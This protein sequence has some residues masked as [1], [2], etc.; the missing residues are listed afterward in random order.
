MLEN[1]I[2]EI[3]H[4]VLWHNKNP[5]KNYLH[6]IITIIE[7]ALS[8][9][10]TYI[11]VNRHTAS[12]SRLDILFKN[13]MH[14]SAYCCFIKDKNKGQQYCY[15]CKSKG[16]KKC[17]KYREGFDGMCILGVH[18]IVKPVFIKDELYGILYLSGIRCI[19]EE[20]RARMLIKKHCSLLGRSE[21]EMLDEYRKLTPAD[22][23]KLIVMDE[24]LEELRQII[25]YIINTIKPLNEDGKEQGGGNGI[26]TSGGKWLVNSVLPYLEEHYKSNISLEKLAGTFFI[27]PQY[28][29]RA[30]KSKIGVNYKQYIKQLKVEEAKIKLTTTS[31]PITDIALSSGFQDSNYF[32]R[33]F[34]NYTGITPS[35]YRKLAGI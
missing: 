10:I 30:F 25:I 7:K 2:N 35:E 5:K 13:A 1:S 3:I 14:S 31:S 19:E 15:I 18:D 4:S 29:C 8:V 21:G 33:V 26:S 32:C 16:I 28:L 11:N 22:A 23:D 24:C 9:N 34:K 6:R 20:Q 27:N 12:D 17:M